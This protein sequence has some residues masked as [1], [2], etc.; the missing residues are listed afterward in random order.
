M[1]KVISYV[2][3]NGTSEGKVVKGKNIPV[4]EVP[5]SATWFSNICAR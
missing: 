4:P 2:M 1:F 3:V 5:I